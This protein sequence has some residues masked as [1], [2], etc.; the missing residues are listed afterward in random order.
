LEGSDGDLI[1][2]LSEHLPGETEEI[3][4]TFS[5]AGV[6]AEIRLDFLTRLCRL[7]LISRV[8]LA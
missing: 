2:L 1:K 5:V 3:H 4:E 6:L 7:P 8:F